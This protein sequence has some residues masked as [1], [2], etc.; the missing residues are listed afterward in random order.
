M[1]TSL[2]VD[3][4]TVKIVESFEPENVTTLIEKHSVLQ[5]HI[6]IIFIQWNL[7]YVFFINGERWR[8]RVTFFSPFTLSSIFT[9]IIY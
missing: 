2:G 5:F 9:I 8:A 3:Q 4:H 7:F 6:L 1:P